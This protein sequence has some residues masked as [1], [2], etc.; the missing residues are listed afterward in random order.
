M[1]SGFRAASVES[2]LAVS[3]PCVVLLGFER[4]KSQRQWDCARLL[5][6][7]EQALR[8]LLTWELEVFSYFA[9]NP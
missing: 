3:D 7:P 8:K 6:L 1:I 5:F 2:K 9:K 4:V